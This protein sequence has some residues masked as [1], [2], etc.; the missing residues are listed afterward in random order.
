VSEQ[1]VRQVIHLIGRFVAVFGDPSRW[2][3]CAG[4]VDQYIESPIPLF[5]RPAN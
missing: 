1:E 5:E 4:I 2:H 3:E